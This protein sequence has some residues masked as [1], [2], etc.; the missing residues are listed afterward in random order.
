M[1]VVQTVVVE[2]D[3]LRFSYQ[4]RPY[5]RVRDGFNTNCAQCCDD[6]GNCC[7]VAFCWHLQV[8]SQYDAITYGHRQH[9]PSVASCLMLCCAD[10][11]T[12]GIA[13]AVCVAITRGRIRDRFGFRCDAGDCFV[14]TA[15]Y[16]CGCVPCVAC[17]NHREMHMRGVFA[18]GCCSTPNMTYLNPPKDAAAMGMFVP[19]PTA[20]QP[21]AANP[22]YP[23]S[24]P[25]ATGYLATPAPNSGVDG[26]A[27][28]YNAGTPSSNPYG[29]GYAYGAAP[30][31]QQ[32]NQNAAYGYGQP[33][34][35]PNTN[36]GAYGY[37]Q[38]QPAP[39]SAQPSYAHQAPP[40]MGVPVQQQ[41]PQPAPYY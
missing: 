27:Y 38:P 17:Q 10:M 40:A 15:L 26:G 29:Q 39:N 36:T 34:P 8:S 30:A 41:C 1:P 22:A 13:S 35:A 18:G 20:P 14:D 23:S 16:C 11:C 12:F 5:I 3:P 28:G 19:Q 25:P 24:P 37:G 6:V 33:Q 21:Y 7:D 32:T 9:S 4:Y 31:P 2:S